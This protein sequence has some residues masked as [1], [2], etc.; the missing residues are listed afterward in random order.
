M[1]ETSLKS[2]IP[3]LLNG[4]YIL[5]FVKLY[6]SLQNMS[7]FVSQNYSKL[8]NAIKGATSRESIQNCSD[9]SIISF[10]T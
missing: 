3:F 6:I 1:S 2:M 10:F 9:K 7:E 8:R 5:Y 4:R